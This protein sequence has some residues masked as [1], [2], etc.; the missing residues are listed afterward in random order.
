M[1]QYRYTTN[2]K[3]LTTCPDCGHDLTAENG[4]KLALVVEEQEIE[5]PSKLEN[6]YLDD[7]S[8]GAVAKGFH[9]GTYCGGCDELLIDM[10]GVEES[11]GEVDDG[12]RSLFVTVVEDHS[13]VYGHCRVAVSDS[14]EEAMQDLRIWLREV[15]GVR[16]KTFPEVARQLKKGDVKAAMD[17]WSEET[18]KWWQLEETLVPTEA[19]NR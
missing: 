3:P 1:Y 13:G 4:V 8:D 7:T 18:G 14:L 2:N 15:E 17:T 12:S 11:D 16:P 5:T 6:G 10:D 9:S 19:V